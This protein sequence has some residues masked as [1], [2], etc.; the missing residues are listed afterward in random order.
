MNT[1]WEQASRFWIS[2]DECSRVA[3]VMRLS[4]DLRVLRRLL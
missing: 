3:A 1:N 4:P 2:E